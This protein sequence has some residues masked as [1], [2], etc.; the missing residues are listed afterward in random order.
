MATPCLRIAVISAPATRPCATA[1]G[2]S[3]VE[4][5]EL[6]ERGLALRLWLVDELLVRGK[7]LLEWRHHACRIFGDRFE[8]ATDRAP[9][10]ALLVVELAIAGAAK[11][12][13]V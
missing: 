7:P 1:N 10:F 9:L 13:Q 8:L 5:D 6:G 4:L 2:S 11:Q 12:R 3:S